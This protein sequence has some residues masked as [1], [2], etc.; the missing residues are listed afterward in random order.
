VFS[1]YVQ[2]GDYRLYS[3]DSHYWAHVATTTWGTLVAPVDRTRWTHVVGT[4]D[5]VTPTTNP[6]GT[7]RLYVNGALAASRRTDLV[8]ME[9]WSSSYALV[10]IG[11]NPHDSLQYDGGI[12][13]VATYDRALSAA[14]V[15]EHYRIG[16][17]GR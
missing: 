10:G 17:T 4:Y 5:V 1:R 13:E 8:P 6:R 2:P 11:S 15:A 16:T 14:E 7:M 3:R 9:P 12:D